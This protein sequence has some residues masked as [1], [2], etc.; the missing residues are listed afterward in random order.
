MKIMVKHYTEITD[1]TAINEIELGEKRYLTNEGDKL[2][3]VEEL[4]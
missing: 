1:L 3:I 2:Y 4:A